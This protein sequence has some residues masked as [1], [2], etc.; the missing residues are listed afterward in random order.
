ME[1]G[2]RGDA[3]ILVRPGDHARRR[4]RHAGVARHP[5]GPRRH[6]EP[7]R[8]RRP[9]V[10]DPGGRRRR[11]DAHRPATGCA[12]GAHACSSPA[13]RSRSTAAPAT[14]TWACSRPSGAEAPAELDTL[15]AWADA[16][17]AGTVQVRAN[18]DTEGDASQGRM[19]GAQGIGLCRTEHMFLAADRLPI[20]RRF[21][22]ADDTRTEQA[23]LDELEDGPDR[24]LRDA[25]SRRWTGCRSPSACSIRRCTSSC[26]TCSSSPCPRGT[27][28]ARRRRQG[29]A[30]GRAPAARGQPDDRHPRGATRRRA[31]RALRDA[32]AGAVQGG[33]HPV[34][35][36]QAV[37]A[38][39]S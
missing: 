5:H 20:M 10:G 33:R 30:R 3:V 26:P 39:R 15:L 29:R 22:L 8:G 19:L 4:A 16:V 35:P 14:S 31:H 6:G 36:R 11:R 27:R 2:D 38:S 24:R 1:A 9:W 37:R 28:R 34:R 32:G 13:T 17:A 7:R 21:I 18:A 25:C 23:A 12:I